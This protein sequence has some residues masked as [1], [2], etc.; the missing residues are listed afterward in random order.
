MSFLYL[1]TPYSHPDPGEREARYV[2][3]LRKT[4]GLMRAGQVVFSPIV[5]THHV[6]RIVGPRPH[7]FWIDAGLPILARASKLLV[8][9]LSGW[10]SS[11]GVAMEI[12]FA[13]RHGIPVE[14]I[15]P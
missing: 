11:I 14:M 8:L 9:R 3:A 5:H 15:D 7:L 12:E 4:A 2:A 10:E 6:E 1:A 13:E